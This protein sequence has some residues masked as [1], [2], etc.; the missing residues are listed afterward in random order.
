MIQQSPQLPGPL[1]NNTSP[2]VMVVE[3]R[4]IHSPTEAPL[5][6][7]DNAHNVANTFRRTTEIQATFP[8]VRLQGVP[9]RLAPQD[10]ILFA[11]CV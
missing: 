7:N 5:G 8:S 11:I 10:D 1:R 4:T 9:R 3:I 6:V 2:L